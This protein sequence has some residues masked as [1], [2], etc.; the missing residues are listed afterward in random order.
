LNKSRSTTNKKILTFLNE[1][2]YGDA[3]KRLLQIQIN[4]WDKLEEGYKN[5]SSLKTKTFWFDAFKIKIQFNAERIF[6]TSAKVDADSIK[7]RNCFL[8]ENNLPKEQKGIILLEKYY[9][10]CNPY[11][12]FPE[13]F[14]IVAK[15]H[16]PQQISSSFSDFVML[17][18]LLSDNYTVIYNGPQC[19]ASAPDHMHFQAGSKY[20]MPIEN[21]FHSIKKEFGDSVFNS[22]ELTL[23]AI[24]DGLRRFFSLESTD[25]KILIKAF[26]S[27]Y[28]ELEKKNGEPMM[29]LICNYDEELRWWLIIF[30]RSKHRPSHYYLKGENQI[31][32]SP[33]AIDLGGVCI[34]PVESD[35]YKIDKESLISIFN[36]V[37]IGV[38][39]FESLRENLKLIFTINSH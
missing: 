1:N 8:C 7:K 14:T 33:A 35:F 21:D 19:G 36:E 38:N 6:S 3:V 15:N 10:L 24:D 18:K 32:L 16:K 5:L 9:L 11:P 4:E 31:I 37:T 2:N 34:L 26:N 27:I 22:K 30:L 25:D 23:T 13:H 12:V 39:D 29:N 20:F 28:N 17:S